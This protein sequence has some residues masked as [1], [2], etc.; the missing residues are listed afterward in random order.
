MLSY[1]HQYKKSNIGA[2]I[3]LRKGETKLGELIAMPGEGALHSFLENTSA[4]F[5]VLGIA[6]DI[7]VLANYGHPGTDTAWNSFLNSF[8]N[9]QANE[10]TRPETIAV[11]GH[12]SFDELKHEIERKSIP[13]QE[14]ITAYGN[15]V[16]TIDKTVAELIALIVAQGKVPIVVG[17]GHNNAY[18]I[19]KGTATALTF[20]DPAYSKGINCVNLDAHLDYRVSEGRHSGNGFRYAK[21]ES[22]LQ[23][24]FVLSVHQ[25]YIQDF[26]LG[27]LKQMEDIKYITYEDIF[28]RQKKSWLRALEE[29]VK[30]V[31]HDHFTG[32]ELDLDSIENFPAS[33]VSPCGIAF[34]E[35]LQYVDHMATHCKVAYLHICEGIATQDHGRVGKAIS[36][37]VSQF[38]KVYSYRGI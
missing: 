32:I 27:E 31:G 21:Q 1:F 7:G 3:R 37:I 11:I 30:F 5:I 28:I 16:S 18:P 20:V 14:K 35:A 6:E 19:I 8:L 33:A 9:V 34:R 29:A 22:L 13:N 10:F 4:T 24:Y 26:I 38:V 36:Y 2:L 17:G 12:F 25:N 23:K 15:I